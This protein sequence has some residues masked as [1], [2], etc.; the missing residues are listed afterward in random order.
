MRGWNLLSFHDH[1]HSYHREAGTQLIG[2]AGPFGGAVMSS[3]SPPDT[4]VQ[5]PPMVV[6][7]DDNIQA[8]QLRAAISAAAV[9]LAQADVHDGQLNVSTQQAIQAAATIFQLVHSIAYLRFIMAKGAHDN[10]VSDAY[11]HIVARSCN[12]ALTPVS[13]HKGGAFYLLSLWFCSAQSPC[14]FRRY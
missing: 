5:N 7:K 13:S 9:G 14:Q 4:P 10:K 6:K 3:P 8:G 1:E 12:Y 2:C 11:A